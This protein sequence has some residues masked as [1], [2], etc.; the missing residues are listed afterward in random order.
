MIELR[1]KSITIIPKKQRKQN[2]RGMKVLQ[3]LSN[4]IN[5]RVGK[6]MWIG[7][8][9]TDMT[10]DA[11]LNDHDQSGINLYKFFF[12]YRLT[13]KNLNVYSDQIK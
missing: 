5:E 8:P 10:E 3:F 11:K 12:I 13:W 7:A 9:T 4:L 6:I 1:S 2:Q